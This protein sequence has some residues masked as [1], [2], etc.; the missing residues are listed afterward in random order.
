MSL[1]NNAN[2][3]SQID[4]VCMLYRVLNRSK[5]GS[6]AEDRLL[7]LCRPDGLSENED[8][9]KR[10]Q[11]ELRFWSQEHHRLWH[12]TTEDEFHL[13]TRF[14]DDS[15]SKPADIARLVRDVLFATP[16]ESVFDSQGSWE[17]VDQ[18]FA[19]LAWVLAL[20][21]CSAWPQKILNKD[22]LR[23]VLSRLPAEFRLNDSELPVALE[24]GH[25]LG[26]LEPRGSSGFVVDAT[27]AIRDAVHTLLAP[28]KQMSADKFLEALA[29]HLPVIDG[30]R[31]RLEVEARMAEEGFRPPEER[32]LSASLSH[33]LYRL[34]IAGSLKIDALSD[35]LNS[36]DMQLPSG[37][38][39]TF[40]RIQCLESRE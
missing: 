24:Y 10:L 26:F 4:L 17:G 34:Q 3:G 36:R 32:M 13:E 25:F 23:E 8:Q 16:I 5:S 39:V 12:K 38:R 29:Q 27:T 35:D 9:K 31:F 7:A 18:L 19:M 30:G 6:L 37:K 22:S 28:G 15:M 11:G 40:S 14:E 33:A 21:E 2:P 1:I 20:P